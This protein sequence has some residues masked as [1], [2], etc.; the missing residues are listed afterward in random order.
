MADTIQKLKHR[1]LGKKIPIVRYSENGTCIEVLDQVN[2]EAGGILRDTWNGTGYE[3]PQNIRPIKIIVNNRQRLGFA[4]S[5]KGVAVNVEDKVRLLDK[6]IVLGTR[7][8]AAEGT[9]EIHLK[10]EGTIGKLTSL[11]MLEQGIGLEPN[12]RAL[13]IRLIVGIL[14]GWLIV[15]PLAS[16]LI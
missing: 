7:D 5:E 15:S 1:F 8:R 11:N 10:Y 6:P 2:I 12:D 13:W 16:G 9:Q 3:V 4:V 14:I